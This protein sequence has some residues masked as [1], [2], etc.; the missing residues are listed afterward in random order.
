V[1]AVGDHPNCEMHWSVAGAYVVG[2]NRTNGTSPDAPLACVGGHSPKQE[3][4]E[5]EQL[6]EEQLEEQLEDEPLLRV[7]VGH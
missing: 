7:V 2:R 1:N 4:L 6:E 5:E 3:Q